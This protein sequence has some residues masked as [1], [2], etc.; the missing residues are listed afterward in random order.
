MESF[1]VTT[2][3]IAERHSSIEILS[4]AEE[5]VGTFITGV[6]EH[7]Q[8]ILQSVYKISGFN[9]KMILTPPALMAEQ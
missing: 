1:I 4:H 8:K 7:I 3:S 2:C 9:I 6:K 5:S